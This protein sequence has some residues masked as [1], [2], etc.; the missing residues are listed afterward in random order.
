MDFSKE[1]FRAASTYEERVNEAAQLFKDG[2]S[3]AK[4]FAQAKLVEAF[5]TSDFPVLLGAALGQ[6]ALQVQKDAVKE[7]EILLTDITVDDFRRRRLVDMWGADEFET[8]EQGEEYKGG[9]LSET[10]LWHGAQKHGKVYGLTWELIRAREFSTLANFPR[11]LANG[12]VKGQ[13]TAVADLLVDDAADTWNS[14]FFGTVDTA[15]FSPE[16]LDA[17]IKAMA[18]KEDHRGDL[19]DM[20]NLVLVYGPG[21]KTEVNRVLKAIELEMQV[22]DGTKVTKTRVANPFSGLVTPLESR[23]IGKKL[24]VNGSM[25]WALVP[26]RGST[27]PAIVRTLLS[28]EEGVDIR[29]KRD[30]GDRPGGG[31]VAPE[32]GSFKDDTIWFRGRDVYGIDKGFTPGVY[33]SKGTGQ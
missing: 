4:P 14:A 6:T 22:T 29:V 3:G 26:G 13:N 20:S 21:L 9:T 18:V 30:Q 17:A 5:S 8:V 23:T 33:A 31:A 24:G 16:N 27:L 19:V 25:G 11:L 7:F 15:K 28:G 10:E 32:E 2:K 1:G 12:S